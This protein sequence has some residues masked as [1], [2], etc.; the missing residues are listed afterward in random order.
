MADDRYYYYRSIGNSSM[1]GRIA[2]IISIVCI[3]ACVALMVMWVRSYYYT[4]DINTRL[5][6]YHGLEFQSTP[7]LLNFEQF[8]LGY[9]SIW[10]GTM[11][12]SQNM[13]IHYQTFNEVDSMGRIGFAG[14]FSWPR[15]KWALPYWFLVLASGFLAIG[16]RAQGP[17]WRFSLRTFLIA[18]MFLAVVLGMTSWL[19]RP[20]LGRSVVLR[21]PARN[22]VNH[23]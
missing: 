6:P 9:P 16:L 14:S 18:T 22:V 8:A 13:G 21:L 17:P 2:N 23:F 11:S 3:V 10:P 7:G 5:G 19:D 1:L 4:D 20:W 15:Q 12:R